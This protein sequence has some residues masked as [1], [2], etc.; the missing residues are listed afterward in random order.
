MNAAAEAGAGELYGFGTWSG[1][2]V[3]GSFFYRNPNTRTGVF[4]DGAGHLLVA[5]LTPDDGVACRRVPIVAGLAHR[6]AL[7]EI[8][9]DPNCFAYNEWFPS[10]FTPRSAAR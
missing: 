2:D 7:A 4:A 1:R 9:A 5:D 10:G 3:D 6:S 8:V